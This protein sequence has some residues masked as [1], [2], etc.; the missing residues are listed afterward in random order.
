MV[1]L[2]KCAMSDGTVLTPSTVSVTHTETRSTFT[3]DQVSNEVLLNILL[4]IPFLELKK[5]TQVC[6]RWRE[7]VEG[8]YFWRCYLQKNYSLKT[9]LG[10]EGPL[11]DWQDG[12]QPMYRGGFD[13]LTVQPAEVFH[14]LPKRLDNGVLF[15]ISI[16]MDKVPSSKT[17][18]TLLETFKTIKSTIDS[19]GLVYDGQMGFGWKSEGFCLMD[20]FLFPWQEDQ[21]PTSE[22]IS[23]IFMLNEDL[24]DSIIQQ[25]KTKSQL[26]CVLSHLGFQ[27]WVSD[28]LC[29]G[30][31]WTQLCFNVH[32]PTH[33]MCPSPVF[34]Y[35]DVAPSWIGGILTGLW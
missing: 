9:Q 11:T 34:L 27:H 21:Q 6:Q 20:V 30:K 4:N 14:H 23:R 26:T 33:M 15:P 29:P 16:Q 25:K 3:T 10:V 17:L 8:S 19:N 35:S 22:D 24:K 31:E 12:L 2:S 18:I 28:A 1:I 7:M 32:D 5:C 13:A